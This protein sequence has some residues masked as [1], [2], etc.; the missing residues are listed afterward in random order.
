MHS[1]L[2]LNFNGVGEGVGRMV[3]KVVQTTVKME[4]GPEQ[5]LY[6]NFVLDRIPAM[7]L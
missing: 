1:F 6:F 3:G 2:Y 7:S 4:D 5:L